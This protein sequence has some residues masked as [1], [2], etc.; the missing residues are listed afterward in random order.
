MTFLRLSDV[1]K[2]WDWRYRDVGFYKRD[3]GGQKKG[4]ATDFD[5]SVDGRLSKS[6]AVQKRKKTKG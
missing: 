3:N 6:Q 5:L 1:I 2:P 4:A